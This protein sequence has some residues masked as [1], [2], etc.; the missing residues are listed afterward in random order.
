MSMIERRLSELRAGLDAVP[1]PSSS[2]PEQPPRMDDTIDYDERAG[3]G[4]S[5]SASGPRVL[6]IPPSRSASLRQGA[7]HGQHFS[8]KPVTARSILLSASWVAR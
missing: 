6:S 8:P 4:G 7:R 1:P 2:S 5:N 3:S